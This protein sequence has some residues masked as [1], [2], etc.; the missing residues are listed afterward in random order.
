[1]GF[2]ALTL[3]SQLRYPLDSFPEMLN[4]AIRTRVSLRRIEI[5]LDTKNVKG[6]PRIDNNI[7]SN[8][9][10][11]SKRMIGCEVQLK[12][13]SLGWL[14][15]LKADDEVLSIESS[16]DSNNFTEKIN[17]QHGCYHTVFGTWCSSAMRSTSSLSKLTRNSLNKIRSFSSSSKPYS[18]LK[19]NDEESGNFELFSEHGL[20]MKENGVIG[21]SENIFNGLIV[22]HDITISIPTCSLAIIVG[23]TG[24]GKSS[25]LQGAF[26]GEG[27]HLQGNVALNGR[28]SYAPQSP[29][30][31]NASLRDN[32]LF[33]CP[34]EQERYDRV[35]YSCSLLSDFNI[36][37]YGN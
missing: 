17:E 15:T 27:I 14:P 18:L 34:Y 37:P 5:F 8:S 12:D 30:I 3:F 36:L 10:I 11:Q 9:S 33:G 35:V 19:S 6:L 16:S 21:L 28:I 7:S 29:W 4:Y 31:Q 32:I 2:T 20:S 22:F 1:M 23:V 13:F 25:L 24:S 26:L